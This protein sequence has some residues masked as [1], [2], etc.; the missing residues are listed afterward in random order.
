[1]ESLMT[2][3]AAQT[4]SLTADFIKARMI[5]PRV[6][7]PSELIGAAILLASDASEPVTGHI[8]MCD[9][10]CLTA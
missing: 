9:D 3:K 2:T 6:G 5:R 4:T 8:I 7:L 10:G 1:M